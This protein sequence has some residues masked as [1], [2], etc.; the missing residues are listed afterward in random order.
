MCFLNRQGDAYYLSTTV[1]FYGFIT[2]F[3]FLTPMDS[4]FNGPEWVLTR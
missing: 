1:G 3:Y 2:V 4:A